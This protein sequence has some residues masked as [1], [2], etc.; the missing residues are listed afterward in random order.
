M[1]IFIFIKIIELAYFI[2]I[3]FVF[4]FAFGVAT[5][6]LLY[7]NQELNF[8]LLGSA[9]LPAYFI[10]SGDDMIRETIM[11]AISGLTSIR[12]LNIYMEL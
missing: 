10:I 2:V 9:F 12:K 1:N 5:Q 7:P 3:V 6:A 4:M 8:M 11:S